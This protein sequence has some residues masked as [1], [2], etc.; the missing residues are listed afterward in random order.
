MKTNKA[1]TYRTVLLF[2]VMISSLKGLAQCTITFN[3]NNQNST[4]I[5]IPADGGTVVLGFTTTG[6]NC[7]LFITPPP[8]GPNDSHGWL[9]VT[10]SLNDNTITVSAPANTTGASRSTFPPFVIYDGSTGS[11]IGSFV[12]HQDT[13]TSTLWFLDSDGDGLRNQPIT[14]QI[15]AAQ[16]SGNWVTSTTDDYCSFESGPASN[17]GCPVGVVPENRNWISSKAYD[18]NGNVKASSKAYFDEL[19]K[20]IQ[21]QSV[22]VKTGRTWA[23]QTLYDQQGRPALNTLSAPVRDSGSFEY[24]PDFVQDNGNSTY[25]LS[26]F[27]GVSNGINKTENPTPVGKLAGTLGYYYSNDNETDTNDSDPVRKKG[28][29]YQDITVYPFS[30]TIYSELIPGAALKTIGG[31]KVDTNDDGN[32]DAW[33]QGYTFSMQAGDELTREGAFND[34]SYKVTSDRKIIKTISRDVHGDEVVVFTDTDGKTLAV[35]RVGG[36]EV[37]D[38]Y[39][40]IGEQGFVDVHVP[41]G[42]TGFINNGQFGIHTEVYDLTTEEVVTADVHTLPSGFYR[43]SVTNMDVYSGTSTPIVIRCKENY[44][45]YSLN[46]YDE[47]GRLTA[48]YQPVGNTKSQK[49][50]TTYSYDALGQLLSTTS[51]DE[52]TANFKYRKDGQIRFSQNSKQLENTEFSYTNYDA[53]GR[54]IE[55]GVFN[56]GSITF[57]NADSIVDN[58]DNPATSNDEDGL[59]DASCS[60]QHFTTY[61]A[62]SSADLAILNGVHSSYG[63]PSFLAV[64]VAK[65]HNDNTTTW[66]SYDVYGRVKWIVQDIT[67]LGV[68]TIDYKYDP[69][70]GAVLELDFQKHV[71]SERFIHKYKYDSVDDRLTL[72]ETSTNGSTW[73]PHALY[74]YY[75]TGALKCIKLAPDD[76]TGTNPLQNVDYVYNLN[77]QLKAINPGNDANDLFSMQIDYHNHD[78]SRA[79]RTD[80]ATMNYGKDQF[81]GNIKG[82]RWNNKNL[83]G[84]NTNQQQTYSYY[85]NKNNWLTDAIYGQYDDVEGDGSKVSIADSNTHQDI[86]KSFNATKRVTWLPGFRAKPGIGDQVTAKIVNGTPSKFQSEQYNVFDITYDANG[87]IRTLNRNKDGAANASEMDQLSYNYNP[88][89]PNQLQHVDDFAGEVLAGKDLADQAPGN[90]E[91]NEIGQL[92]KNNEEN[93]EYIYNASGLVTIVKKGGSPMVKFFYNDKG[94]RVRK[95][96]YTAAT[97]EFYVRDAA[98]ATMAIYR[99]SLSSP[100]LSVVEHTIYGSS[101]LGVY[102]PA[103]NGHSIYQLTDHLGNVRAVVERDTGGDAAA[104]VATDYYPFGMSMPNRDNGPNSYRYK[105]QGQEKDPETGKEAFELRLWDSRIGRWLTTDPMHEFHSPYLGM[106]NNPINRID[107]DGGETDDWK[108]NKKTGEYVWDENVTSAAD[109][110]DPSKFEYVGIG[111]S[112]ITKHYEANNNAFI[113]FFKGGPDINWGSF[114][115]YRDSHVLSRIETYLNTGEAQRLDDI[116]GLYENSAKEFGGHLYMRPKLNINVRG[117]NLNKGDVTIHLFKNKHLNIIDG[118]EFYTQRW[119]GEVAA[120]GTPYN[121][122]LFSSRVEAHTPRPIVHIKVHKSLGD[123]FKTAQNSYYTRK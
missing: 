64:N 46:E 53:L 120:V 47:A 79:E 30:R 45:D 31:N 11:G 84:G 6:I 48:S 85:Y 59:P 13:S 115:D 123:A 50:V 39:I 86:T 102:R 91:Y 114:Y 34:P 72:V 90:Y 68:K 38:T 54:P 77:G 88:E 70:T 83:E 112:D 81:N 60:E 56:E 44:Y 101:R 58:V 3:N 71:A 97:T 37:R 14:S 40:T 36:T 94:Y 43:V 24:K 96:I 21:S 121:I 107:P 20:P 61:D 57:A 99:S 2:I 42:T 32:A 35:A 17:N 113:R 67:G 5:E 111:K 16:P 28:D 23:T 49:P 103:G 33:L 118:A 7:P 69:I 108:Y 117:V 4:G 10:M 63:K 19:G 82:I 55:S 18:I 25:N 26:D 74:E 105:Y 104:L 78:Y 65:T 87:N 119:N 12:V 52:G 116:R 122:E 93:I 66:Y 62:L 92:V 51:P 41:K 109:I 76:N 106:G 1:F 75:E 110:I 9:T 15:S 27:E 73:T 95:D 29:S 22:D 89:K 80:V 98:G 100:T 8:P